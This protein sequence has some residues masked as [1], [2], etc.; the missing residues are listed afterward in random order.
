[1]LNTVRIGLFVLLVAVAIPGYTAEAA[2]PPA[3]GKP[4]P[5]MVRAAV[6]N[7]R[8]H[9]FL[10]RITKDGRTSFLYGTIHVATLDWMFPGPRVTQAIRATDTMALELD[11]L[12]ADIQARMNKGMAALHSMALPE[13]LMKRIRQQAESECVPYA[14]L[15]N[16]PPELQIAMLVIMV[17]RWEGLDV[18]YAIDIVLA[19]IGHRA[20]KNM[21]S[22]ETP[23]FQLQMMLMKTPEE[24]MAYVKDSLDELETGRSRSL[25]KR[26]SKAWTNADYAEMENFKEWCECLNT[27]TEREVMR[28]MIDERSSPLADKIDALHGSGKRVFAAVGSL[29]MFGPMGLPTL[30]ANRG[31]QV[32]RV[33]LKQ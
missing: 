25:L 17:G 1:M 9:G 33:D 14:S 15:A 28:R 5:E 20:K 23:E 24:T 16:A 26:L 30:M 12:D 10:W 19:E 2:C 32:E 27:V 31:Y 29:H 6:L 3:A 8:D 4:T 11:M 18:S 13:P 21:V 7:A 22:L